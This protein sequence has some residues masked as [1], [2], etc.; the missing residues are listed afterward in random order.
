MVR[1]IALATYSRAPRLAADDQLLPP[2]LA[3]LGITA[4]PVVWSNDSAT[5]SDFDA[6]VVRS[7]WDYH[8]QFAEFLAWLARLDA[9]GIAV[10]NSSPLVRW[11]ADKR[12]LL[13][14][15]RRGVA[16]IPTMIVPRGRG[17]DVESL[18]IAEGWTRFVLKPTVSASGY[19]TYALRTPL[20]DAARE[21]IAKVTAIGDALLQPFVEEVPRYGEYSFTFI[22]GAF[23]HATLKRATPGEFRVQ[24]EHGGSVE[25][26]DAPRALVEQ[27]T[28]ALKVLPETPLYARVDGIARGSAFLLMELELIEPNLFLGE[29]SG[30]AERLAAAIDRRVGRPGPRR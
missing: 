10:W 9:E 25:P 22:D 19:E 2:A 16:T 14:L 15:A 6:V 28:H 17:C 4:E 23:S 21:A 11:N 8:L 12:Y 5:W 13:D 29:A 1:R 27:A 26:V 20:D 7:C 18:A 24:T 3:S 30:A